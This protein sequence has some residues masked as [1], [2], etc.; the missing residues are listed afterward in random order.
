MLESSCCSDGRVFESLLDG[1]IEENGWSRGD[2]SAFATYET[3]GRQ[4]P[5]QIRMKVWVKLRSVIN[6]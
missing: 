1:W 3:R 5:E 6:G 2:E 4:K